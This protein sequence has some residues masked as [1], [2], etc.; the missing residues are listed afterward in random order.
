MVA[1]RSIISYWKL[2]FGIAVC[3][4]LSFSASDV[5]AAN[6][7]LAW[8][9]N[10]EKNSAGYKIH[11]GTKSRS[12]TTT[13]DVG[14][15]IS[16]TITG[17]K[18]GETYYFAVTAYNISGL[19][20]GYS[21]EAICFFPAAGGASSTPSSTSGAIINN[22]YSGAAASGSGQASPSKDPYNGQSLQS[23][24]TS[25][26]Y[27]LPEEEEPELII[28]N[29]DPE[30]MAVGR[31]LTS[32][33]RNPFEGQSLYS[34]TASN[35][36]A[37]ESDVSGHQEV[38]MW[39]TAS[40]SRNTSVPVKIYD[41]TTL[42]DT[43]YVDQTKNGGKWNLLGSYGFSKSARVVIVS[44]SHTQTTCADAVGFKEG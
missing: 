35:T 18:E 36:F 16:R 40:S 7:T 6:V 17:L 3:F 11:Y 20:S 9:P 42:I 14:K 2:T 43:V 29:D 10:T 25:G 19:S 8:D 1:T 22:G 5:F 28:D 24:S 37:F 33:G 26:S 21:N 34:K 30:T 39:W 27:T 41:G 38:Y 31:W 12:Y 13:I 23:K 15:V 32:S 44:T 4:F